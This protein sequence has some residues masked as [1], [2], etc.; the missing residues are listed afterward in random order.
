[1]TQGNWEDGALTALLCLCSLNSALAM[2]SGQVLSQLYRRWLLMSLP[3]FKKIKMLN[4]PCPFA[5]ISLVLGE[6]LHQ[7]L[8]ASEEQ[9][10][11][12]C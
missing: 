1:M 12:W 4:K 6:K 5:G 11:S 7:F 8:K 10:W 9:H 2:A 3:N